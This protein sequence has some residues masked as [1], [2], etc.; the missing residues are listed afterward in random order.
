MDYFGAGICARRQHYCDIIRQMTNK[1]H[2]KPASLRILR[3][4]HANAL[5]GMSL[6][7]C[8]LIDVQAEYGMSKLHMNMILSAQAGRC[9]NAAQTCSATAAKDD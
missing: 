9:A 3:R 7:R 1:L 4:N 6:P 5:S 8:S 2:S